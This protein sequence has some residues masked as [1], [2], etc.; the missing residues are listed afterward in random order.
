M[1]EETAAGKS[2]FWDIFYDARDRDRVLNATVISVK[3]PETLN[4]F[5]WELKF[6]G[7][8]DTAAV[9]GLVPSSET[10]LPDEDMMGSFVNKK[11]NVKVKSI[12]KN[13][14]IVACTRR[15]VVE[16]A[17]ARLMN[18]LSEGEETW[19]L[20]RFVSGG[21]LGLD[22]GGGVVVGVPCSRAAFSR[23]VPL[24]MQY[25]PGQMVRVEIRVVNR[26]KSEIEISVKNPWENEKFNRGDIVTGRVLK[27]DG[28]KLFV[29][30][31]QGVI[32]LAGCPVGKRVSEGEQLVFQVTAFNGAERKLHM[33]LFD[34]ERIRGRRR[35]RARRLR[36]GNDKESVR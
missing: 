29:E 13:S 31:R 25:R 32:G 30:V 4:G 5:Y 12:D 1:P 2:G 15:E 6:E 10:G 8:E 9:L 23:S 18:T 16:E 35:A 3:R 24:D 14:G 27:V 19:S 17:R 22:I 21:R 36:T 20:V 11:V 26:E 33:V 34:S 28:D 7:F